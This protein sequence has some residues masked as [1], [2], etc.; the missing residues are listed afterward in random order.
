[1]HTPA[2]TQASPVTSGQRHIILDALRGFALLGICMANY[3]EFSLYSFLSADSTALMSTARADSITQFLLYMFV[4]GKFYT[5]FSILFGI[6]FSIIITNASR[7]GVNGYRIFYRRMCVLLIIGLLHLMLVWSGDIL[8]LY[9]LMGMLLPLFIKL[10]DRRLLTWAALLLLLPVIID[11]VCQLTDTY[12][13]APIVALQHSY[14]DDYG[15][16][17]ANFAYW[18]RDAKDYPTVFQF[19]IQG[20]VV[21]LQEFVD[22]HRYFKVLGLFLIGLY[23]GRH[24]VFADLSA[25]RHLLTMT[26]IRCLIIGLPL[27]ALYSLDSTMGRPYGTAVHSTIYLASVYPLSFAY[28]AALCLLYMKYRD[29]TLWR[30]L[31]APGRMALT[32]YL[33]QSVIGMIIF[34]GIGFGLGASLG[35]SHVELI[36]VS[37]YIVQMLISRLWARW[38][39][40]GPLEWIWRMF[41]YGRLLPLK[42]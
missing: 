14:C 36:A 20:A 3:P 39:Q 27:S 33:S 16:T 34:Y 19:L 4:D 12:L 30:C 6:G 31:A 35:L 17:D 38:F 28:I 8:A 18:L 10:S 42:K 25:H 15:I 1:M 13:S 29:L 26:L 24:R 9:A 11:T 5:I 41:T 40:Y 37:V 7:K 2:T 32:N 22:G 21:R 23:I